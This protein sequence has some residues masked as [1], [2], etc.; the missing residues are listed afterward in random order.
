MSPY[1]QER[2]LLQPHP[3]IDEIAAAMILAEIGVS[4]EAFGKKERLSA[5]AEMTPGA[6]QSAGKKK[7]SRTLH[8][9]QLLKTVLCEV[10][11][12]ARQIDSQ[13]KGKFQSLVIRRGH[14]RAIVALGHKV[15]EVIFVMLKNKIPYKDPGIDYDKLIVSRNAPRWIKVLTKCG[16]LG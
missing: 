14:K 4:M 10:A 15:L 5:W 12:A 8:G 2:E 1:R 16:Y 9:D 11:N 13:Y 6:N 7:S 3:G